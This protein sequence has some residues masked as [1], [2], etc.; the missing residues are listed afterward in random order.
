MTGISD[1]LANTRQATAYCLYLMDWLEW[2]RWPA[3][4]VLLLKWS[5]NYIEGKIPTPRI[6]DFR[7]SLKLQALSAQSSSKLQTLQEM[8]RTPLTVLS[9]L[10]VTGEPS[11]AF[12]DRNSVVPRAALTYQVPHSSGESLSLLAHAE[13]TLRHAGKTLPK[14]RPL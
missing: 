6:P 1:V 7:P 5:T 2:I 8:A 12:R 3:L 11:K 4:R 10:Q 14:F 9:S 13:K